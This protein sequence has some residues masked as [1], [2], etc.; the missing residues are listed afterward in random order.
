MVAI[1]ALTVRAL[2][3]GRRLI[4]VALLLTIP[5]LLALVYRGSEIHPDGPMFSVRMVERLL[6][7]VLIPLTALILGTSALGNEVEDRTLLYLVL[8]PVPR[9]L[10]AVA[11]LLAVALITVVLIEISILLMH[12][13]AVSGLKH[14]SYEGRVLTGGLVVGF[15][16]S[17][18]YCSIFLP[19]GLLAPRRGLIIGLAYVLIWEVTVVTFSTLLAT[20]SVRRYVVGALD[21]TLQTSRLI[22][23]EKAGVD[24]LASALVLAGIVVA[25]TVFT[26][27]WLGRMEIP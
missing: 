1:F 16:G 9:W 17:V 12:M 10:I 6:L 13:I 20:L 24:G 18:A 11:K 21:A 8:R 2:S 5:P 7:P 3:R 25:A 19:L 26:T 14:P 23:L 15:A 4:V 27:W 22:K